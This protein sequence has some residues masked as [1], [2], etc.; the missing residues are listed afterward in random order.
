VA[1]DRRISIH[2]ADMRHGRKSRSKRFD[3]YKRHVMND[4]DIPGLI[5]GGL[6]TPANVPEA[7]AAKPLI[8]QLETQGD[9]LAEL[10]IDRGYLDSEPVR[11]RPEL[12]LV[13]KPFPVQN[14]G[15]FSKEEFVLDLEAMTIA[16]PGGVTMPMALGKVVEF[17]AERCAAC[18]MRARCT[19]SASAGRNVRIHEQ[20]PLQARLRAVQ[21]TPQGRESYRERVAIEHQLARIGMTQGI[22]ARYRGL[23][24]NVFDLG[25]HIVVNNCYVLD[26]LWREAA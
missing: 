18:P 25:R 22:R 11:T 1:K 20:E 8:E 7:E 16:C 14:G 6:V 21:R 15:L 13:A 9:M 12:K 4:L 24:K 23:Q 3:G 17:P 2:D 26:G 5:R 19:T 10:H